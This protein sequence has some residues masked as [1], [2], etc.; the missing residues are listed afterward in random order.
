MTAARYPVNKLASLSP[1]IL[2]LF[3]GLYVTVTI[4]DLTKSTSLPFHMGIL[5]PILNCHSNPDPKPLEAISNPY[6]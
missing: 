1:P 3:L 6:S 4:I 5:S 2:L